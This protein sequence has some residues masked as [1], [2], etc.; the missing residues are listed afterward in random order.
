LSGEALL[1]AKCD[2]NAADS[3]GRTPLMYAARYNRHTAVGLL[4][5]AGVNL[6]AQ[7]KDGMTALDL[8]R[9]FDNQEVIKLLQSASVQPGAANN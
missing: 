1:G 8:A 9:K 6:K 7:D 2:I 3:N 5:E 4:L